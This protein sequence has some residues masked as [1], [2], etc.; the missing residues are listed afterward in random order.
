MYKVSLAALAITAAAS[1]QLTGC[2]GTATNAGGP[3]NVTPNG[4]ARQLAGLSQQSTSAGVKES[5]LHRYAGTVC[6]ASTESWWP[7]AGDLIVDAGGTADGDFQG[8]AVANYVGPITGTNWI[9]FRWPANDGGTGVDL[10][11]TAEF[12]FPG[13]ACSVDLDGSPGAGGIK[14]TLTTTASTEYLVSFWLSGNDGNPPT[15]KTMQIAAAGQSKDFFWDVK[16]P[17]LN[18]GLEGAYGNT[19]WTFRATGATTTLSFRSLDPNPA[20]TNAGPMVTMIAV[21]PYPNP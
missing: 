6:P 19:Y 7:P 2:A 21:T 11:P 18:G 20:R 9:A 10:R 8:A 5:G 15:V 1:I 12:P 17:P 4:G 3:T 16:L 14:H 13:G